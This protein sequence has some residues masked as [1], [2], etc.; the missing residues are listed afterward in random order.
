MA[1]KVTL[2]ESLERLAELENSLKDLGV[3]ASSIPAI[4]EHLKEYADLHAGLATAREKQFEDDAYNILAIMN[5]ASNKNVEKLAHFL[6]DFAEHIVQ[7]LLNQAPFAQDS[8]QALTDKIPL[9]YRDEEI[10]EN[11]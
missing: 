9:F 6:R 1:I 10:E 7:W 2:Q 5:A 4:M 11:A 3:P 8:V